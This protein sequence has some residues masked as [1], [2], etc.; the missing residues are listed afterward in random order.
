MAEKR[1]YGR[2]VQKHDVEA[3]WLKATNFVPMQGEVIVYDIDEN[4]NYERIKIGDGIQNVNA[5]PFVDDVLR[6]ELVAQINDVDDRV[7][8]VS[9]LIGDASV[10][11]QIN[12]ALESHEVSWNDL[13]DRPFY[14]EPGEYITIIE[15]QTVTNGSTVT[16]EALRTGKTYIMTVNG[17][18]YT[19]KSSYLIE[20]GTTYISISDP[21]VMVES[22]DGL[23]V[24]T[25]GDSVVLSVKIQGEDTIVPIPDEYLPST[26]VKS[27]DGALPN[28]SGMVRLLESKSFYIDRD[29]TG[30]SMRDIL[31]QLSAESYRCKGYV[32]NNLQENSNAYQGLVI[33]ADTYGGLDYTH[34]FILL[35]KL[36]G[37]KVFLV[38]TDADTININGGVGAVEIQG[39]LASTSYVDSL[40]YAN[41]SAI[42][43]GTDRIAIE[44]NS[45]LNTITAIGCYKCASSN[46]VNS[47]S[48]C[49][50]TEAFIM[51]VISANG[52]SVGITGTYSYVLQTLITFTGKMYVRSVYTLGNV[53]EVTYTDWAKIYTSSN[54]PSLADFGVQANATEL[55]YVD[56]VTSNIQ[57]QLNSKADAT[58]VA[59]QIGALEDK[60][61]DTS[62]SEQIDAAQIVYVGPTMPTDPNIKVWINTVEDGTGVIPVL[63]RVATITLPKVSWT[64]SAAPYSQ[65]VQI[66]TVTSATKIDLQPTVAQ[67][68]SLQNDDIALMAENVDGVV[69]IYSFGGKPS[70]DMTMQVLLTEVSFV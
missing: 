48:N 42:T 10:S 59:T 37:I 35:N 62:V 33:Y 32:Y 66:N 49:P 45:D 22:N 65:V 18:D 54:K 8:A 4:Y 23:T 38:D 15:E 41:V 1:I 43:Y 31:N 56:G 51:D 24:K 39:D 34:R 26:V 12:V 60:V 2:A 63:P 5:L 16:G 67:I 3:N 7:D 58:T 47:L 40:T 21:Y 50:A 25:S 46:H 61:G 6:A 57:I 28:S 70:A 53:N 14:K 55:N 19:C 9:A 44:A 11:E 27:V 64:G 52:A 29:Y 30:T 20:S 36:G 69:T 17:V 68:V 13:N